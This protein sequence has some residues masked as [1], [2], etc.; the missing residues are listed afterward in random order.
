[1]SIESQ[2]EILEKE[3][4]AFFSALAIRHFP[5]NLAQWAVLTKVAIE[6]QRASE[7]EYGGDKHRNVTVNLSRIAGILLD[8]ISSKG[9]EKFASRRSLQWD[10]ELDAMTYR[11]LKETHGYFHAWANLSFWHQNRFEA[12]VLGRV[13]KFTSAESMREKQVKAFQKRMLKKVFRKPPSESLAPMTTSRI[14]L[15]ERFVSSVGGERSQMAT[16]RM[17]TELYLEMF[18]WFR[19]QSEMLVRHR[20]DI[21]FA[22]YSMKDA[23]GFV[24]ALQ[25]ICAVHD[26]I[27]FIVANKRREFP[28]NSAVLSKKR[29][30]WIQELS[31]VSGTSEGPISEIISDLTFG[32]RKA[33]DLHTELFVPLDEKGEF[34]GLLPHFGLSA[35]VDENLLRTLSRCE[36]KRYDALA[37]F[38]EAEMVDD[39]RRA[40]SRV[41]SVTGPYELPREAQTNLDI[42]VVDEASSTVLL[43]ELKWIRKPLFAKERIR[44]DEEFLKGIDQLARLQRFLYKNPSYLKVR[45]AL[46]RDLSAYENVHFALAGR[47]HIVW[48][49]A[50]P[51]VPHN[52]VR[53]AQGAIKQHCRLGYHGSGTRQI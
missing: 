32:V 4:D 21:D 25:T 17:P 48:P 35:A 38:K 10:V 49:V 46:S 33:I 30:A 14:K 24:G 8:E 43:A 26:H 31:M 36:G 15:F 45:G 51:L 18:P 27:C 9:N 28:A 19:S 34:L 50:D 6:V 16:Y 29:D 39:L 53:G 12:T 44:A 2:I 5:H 1:M 11:A 42:V 22:R 7:K 3:V 13:I 40:A 37:G 52:R 20:D 23:K 41:V 47:D